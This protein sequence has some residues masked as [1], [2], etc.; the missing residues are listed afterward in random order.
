M[1][2]LTPLER[3]ILDALTND[4]EHRRYVALHEVAMEVDADLGRVS[5]SVG[6]M[7]TLGLVVEDNA[8]RKCARRA[9]ATGLGHAEIKKAAR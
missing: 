5:S 7:K 8:G 4:P 1:I 3:R 9:C 6:Y 2:N